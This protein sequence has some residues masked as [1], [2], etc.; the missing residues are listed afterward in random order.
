MFYDPV[1]LLILETVS[2]VVFYLCEI[3]SYEII[4]TTV[5]SVRGT[6]SSDSII[7]C[8][9]RNFQKIWKRDTRDTSKLKA[10]PGGHSGN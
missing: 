5:G 1:L 10:R 3:K 7:V 8:V 2:V 6:N 4:D 9:R